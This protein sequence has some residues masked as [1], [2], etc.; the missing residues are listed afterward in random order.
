MGAKG[1]PIEVTILVTPGEWTDFCKACSRAHVS[2]CDVL[3]AFMRWTARRPEILDLSLGLPPGKAGVGNRRQQPTPAN[4]R[5]GVRQA[6][7]TPD[8]HYSYAARI[9]IPKSVIK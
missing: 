9:Y 7:G 2:P 3:R 8:F 1:I 4:P 5:K 6:S